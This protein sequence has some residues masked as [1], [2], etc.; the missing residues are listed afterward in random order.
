MTTRFY[1]NGR[2][3]P[4]AEIR[5]ALNESARDAGVPI[6][7]ARELFIGACA[8]DACDQELIENLIPGLECV[9]QQIGFGT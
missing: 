1:C 8:G 4:A 7:M 3:V 6:E 5:A 9:T 2:E